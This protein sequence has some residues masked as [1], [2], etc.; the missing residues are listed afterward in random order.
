MKYSYG[1]KGFG[2]QLKIEE[3]KRI[4]GF[5][6]DEGNCIFFADWMESFLISSVWNNDNL[7]V[8]LIANDRV[9]RMV[10]SPVKDKEGFPR[11]PSPGFGAYNN[12][13]GWE[14]CSIGP[15]VVE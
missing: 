13:I 3:L 7:G 4:P 6:S 5:S 15:V 2:D 12:G 8:E 14:I 9:C 11:I 1:K 10:L